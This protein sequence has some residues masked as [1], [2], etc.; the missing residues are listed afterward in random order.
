MC[1]WAWVVLGCCTNK[2]TVGR[3]N[4]EYGLRLTCHRGGLF[5][6]CYCLLRYPSANAFGDVA[7]N[8]LI[9]LLLSPIK[10]AVVYP[11]V[12]LVVF[13]T[14]TLFHGEKR[15]NSNREKVDFLGQNAGWEVFLN[16]ALMLNIIVWYLGGGASRS[17]TWRRLNS[18]V[19]GC[20]CVSAQ[21][22]PYLSSSEVEVPKPSLL[23]VTNDSSSSFSAAGDIL[24]FDCV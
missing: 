8:K 22:S 3:W 21:S 15:E 11:V 6:Y 2:A 16:F 10:Y 18:A 14:V 1:R 17:C 20:G 12:K 19:L 23:G 7:G 4:P 5:H 24:V 13:F 9:S